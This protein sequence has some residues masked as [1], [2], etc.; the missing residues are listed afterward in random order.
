M[1]VGLATLH[2]NPFALDTLTLVTV[3]PPQ[4][5]FDADVILPLLSTVKLVAV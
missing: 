3:P 4:T 5:P 2:D 1:V